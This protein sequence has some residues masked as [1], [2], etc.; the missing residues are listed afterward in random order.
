[1]STVTDDDAHV[2]PPSDAIGAK[3]FYCWQPIASPP[4]V[5]WSGESGWIHLHPPC[6]VEFVMRLLHDVHDIEGKLGF[7]ITDRRGFEDRVALTERAVAL[8]ERRRKRD[9]DR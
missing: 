9:G 5:Q 1:M 8:A 7:K 6:V 3:C 4:A 2:W